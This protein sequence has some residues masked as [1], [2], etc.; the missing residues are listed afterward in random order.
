MASSMVASALLSGL[1][2][3][4]FDRLAS[5]QIISFF[6]PSH[7]DQT[8]LD[9]LKT[10][11]LTVDAV[12]IDAEEQQLTNPR[13]RD[14]VN[15][16]K[17]AVYDAD[18]LLDEIDTLQRKLEPDQTRVN[19]N[20]VR[21]SPN[22]NIESSLKEIVAELELLANQRDLLNLKQN[23]IGKPPPMLPTTSLVCESEVF[24]RNK[25]IED[26][27]SELLTGNAPENRIPVVAIV[28]IPGVGKT[29]L[30]QLLYNDSEVKKEFDCWAWVYVSE[31]FDV[32][33]TTRTIYHS[34]TSSNCNV[35]D[36]NFLQIR[37]QE[38][39][40]EKRFLLI[41]DNIWN[42]KFMSWDLLSSPLKHGAPG[43]R[44]VVT[45]R[46]QR[47]AAL[48]GA[49][50]TCHLLPLKDDDCWSL[51][52][53]H[54]FRTRNDVK[55]PFESIGKEIVKEKCKGIPLAAKTLGGLLYSKVEEEE[56]R[57][58]LN[59]EIWDLP[60]DNSILPALRLS[61]FYLPSQ[62]KRCFNYCSMFPRGYE[63][64]KEKLVLLWMAE[65]FL[66]QGMETMEQK[67]LGR[68]YF[69]VLL[70]RSFFQKSNHYKF[71]FVMHDLIH[72]LAQ[73]TSGEFYCKFEDGRL[74]SRVEKARHV[75]WFADQLDGCEKFLNLPKSLRTF[76][77]LRKFSCP[78]QLSDI[79]KTWL[80]TMPDLKN[81][82]VLSFSCYAI[83]KLPDSLGE[84]I[85]L[86]YLDVSHTHIEELPSSTWSLINL[87]TLLLSG[88]LRLRVSP[89]NFGDLVNLC[90][91]DIS[92]TTLNVPEWSRDV[93]VIRNS[94]PE[95]ALN[96]DAVVEGN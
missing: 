94:Y 81:L 50:S 88:C 37:L 83:N 18:N 14:W 54:A 55:E 90:H 70:S 56:W 72:D 11:L 79:S 49:Y 34:F 7:F 13:V 12:L 26:L 19:G 42:E 17:D 21:H 60:E 66:Q 48:M 85:L 51:F 58:I 32:F 89:E 71:C 74:C 67:K 92:G 63:F 43:S 15:R 69:C 10:V 5:R 80:Y 27:R 61:Y 65:G 3:V 64:D 35:R 46:N 47:V 68:E 93:V 29:T 76:L 84:L 75:A 39:L 53:K 8:L 20:K 31:E 4:L 44:I 22:K 59:S 87:Q 24:G 62:L 45:A 95:L 73:F 57:R 6:Q 16:L 96:G 33:D 38:K 36:L 25:D 30:A 2:Q 41:L 9:K 52:A 78:S 86:R 23:V 77:P 82:R 40:K 91:L 28:G 1:F